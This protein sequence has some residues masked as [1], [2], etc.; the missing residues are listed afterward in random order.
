MIPLD[1]FQSHDRQMKITADYTDSLWSDSHYR[2]K[3]LDE[4]GR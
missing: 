1:T 2:E 3:P 4:V